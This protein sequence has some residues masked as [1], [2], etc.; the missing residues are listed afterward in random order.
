MAQT[1]APHMPSDICRWL[2]DNELAVYSAEYERTGFQGGLEG[3]RVWADGANAAELKLF[4]GL[5]IDIPSL[6][7]SGKK[8][9]GVYQ[10]PG[11]FEA[12]QK[13]ACTHM[14]GAHLIEGAGHWVQQEQP[15]EVVRMLMQF[16]GRQASQ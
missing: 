2:P 12:M 5:T 10:A 1:V 16:L 3:Y 7:I 4:Y 6:F 13:T 14:H 11:A 15:E 9:W 8:D